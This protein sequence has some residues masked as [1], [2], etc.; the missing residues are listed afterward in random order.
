[1]LKLINTHG[2]ETWVHESRLDEYLA[3]GFQF[4]APPMPAPPAETPSQKPTPKK[5]TRKAR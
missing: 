4:A 2:G 1:M 3:R 5:T